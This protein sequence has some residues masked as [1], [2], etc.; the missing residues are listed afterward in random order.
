MAAVTGALRSDAT[1]GFFTRVLMAQYADQSYFAPAATPHGMLT[2]GRGSTCRCGKSVQTT[3]N[4]LWTR[5]PKPVK[6]SY[7][8]VFAFARLDTERMRLFGGTRRGR[9]DGKR[10]AKTPF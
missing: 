2:L 5:Q 10:H 7:Q 3:G 1:F 6:V 8:Y 4:R 9:A